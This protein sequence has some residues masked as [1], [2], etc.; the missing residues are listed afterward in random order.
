MDEAYSINGCSVKIVLSEWR[1][2]EVEE[3]VYYLMVI[4]KIYVNLCAL[5]IRTRHLL[6]ASE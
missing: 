3:P 4:P 1:A 6:S 5:F 2:K